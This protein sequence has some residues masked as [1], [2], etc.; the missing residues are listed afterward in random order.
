[1]KAVSD[2]TMPLA[3][4]HFATGSRQNRRAHKARGAGANN[5]DVGLRRHS[6][7]S[8]AASLSRRTKPARF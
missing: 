5:R 7:V 6:I 3:H 1:M 4:D 2:I 8:L